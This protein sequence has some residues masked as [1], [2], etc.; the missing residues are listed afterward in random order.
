VTL[1]AGRT[2]ISVCFERSAGALE[3]NTL[4]VRVQTSD[5]Q[6][7]HDVQVIIPVITSLPQDRALYETALDDLYLERDVFLRGT[8]IPLR[9][10]WPH[11]GLTFTARFQTP[12]G[13]IYAEAFDVR[14]T[15]ERE[16]QVPANLPTGPYQVLL[17]PDTREFHDEKRLRV[18]RVLPLALAS[19]TFDQ[20]PT[21]DAASRRMAAL[22]HA[23][24]QK[25][26]LFAELAKMAL[27]W[28]GRLDARALRSACAAAAAGGAEGRLALLG[29]LVMREHF[30]SEQQFPADLA[31][32]IA[33]AARG[34]PYVAA[35]DQEDGD[36]LLALAAELL[37]GQA[38]P[39]EQLA[40]VH[41]HVR[42][43]QAET[44]ALTRLRQMGK[45]GFQSWPSSANAERLAV[46]LSH[47]L[48]LSENET[49]CELASVLL[50]KLC[51]SL[52]LNS[53]KGTLGA[54]RASDPTSTVIGGRLAPTAG[55]SWLL[56]GLG[57]LNHHIAGLVS[58]AISH[59]ELPPLL[60]EIAADQPPELV[61]HERH[62]AVSLTTF[63]T[64]EFMLAAMAAA[65]PGAS[66]SA[67]HLW[68]ATLGPEAVVFTNH[69]A[70][71]SLLDLHQ[72][73]FWRGNA[74]Q[75]RVAH[76]R[77]SVI[78]IYQAPAGAGLPFTHAYFPTHAFDEYVLDGHWAFARA[79]QGYLGLFAAAGLSLIQSGDHAYRELRS[80]GRTNVWLGCLGRATEVGS[81]ADF[82]QRLLA[83]PPQVENSAV[84]WKGPRGD[85][86]A[87]GWQTPL[88][89]NDAA[90]PAHGDWHFDNPY[91][92]A[93]LGADTIEIV[94]GAQGL[95]LA[96]Q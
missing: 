24:Q 94:H 69:P 81:F 48:T 88:S 56:W 46:A 72:P 90:P 59:Y 53:Y 89:V 55:L 68:Q 34:A 49:L 40:G 15:A 32:A 95:R 31:E 60:A 29:L 27:G 76:W 63:K 18:S 2:T 30:S 14:S 37:A 78:V 57:S 28:W 47:I 36:Y 58:L 17:L 67:E 83:T 75:P 6:P 9:W 7:V 70:N 21:G 39:D 92:H 23:T 44:A 71:A 43:L 41:G 20:T 26:Q 16:L 12:E 22:N 8:R 79:G 86:L 73:N 66:G 10:T 74:I 51:F 4:R 38:F 13:L 45:Q 80:P 52:G 11:K 3:P 5:A 96:F 1:V 65:A 35:N 84:R 87:V 85:Q 61:S 62:H 82:R 33:A 91:S 25:G 77:E 19:A 64:P 54:P 93:R 50:D 42:R